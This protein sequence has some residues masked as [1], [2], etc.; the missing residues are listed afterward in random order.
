MEALGVLAGRGLS[1]HHGEC[2]A[3]F[4]SCFFNILISQNY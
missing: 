3:V 1:T 2:G 4:G